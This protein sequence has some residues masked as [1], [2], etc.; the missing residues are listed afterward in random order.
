[1]AP[2]ASVPLWANP[3]HTSVLFT[4]FAGD[5]LALSARGNAD[6]ACRSVTATFGDGTVAQIYNG[7]LAPDDQVEMR[8]PGGARNIRRMD[9][10][11]WSVDRGRAV[12]NVTAEVLPQPVFVPLG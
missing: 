1:M 9:F 5:I 7:T 11:C 12:L 6:V 4:N 3:A 8:V 10:D 2:A